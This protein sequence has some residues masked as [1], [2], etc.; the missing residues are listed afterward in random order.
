MAADALEEGEAR[1]RSLALLEATYQFP[2]HYAVTVIAFN[3]EVVTIAIRGVAGQGRDAE[4]ESVSEI[5]YESR[6]SAAGKYLSH[7][8]AVWVT[9]AGVVLELYAR[10]RAMEGVVT[11]F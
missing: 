10:L 7:R 4:G 1:A 11:M 9:H 5:S 8:F 2:C 3:R 6:A